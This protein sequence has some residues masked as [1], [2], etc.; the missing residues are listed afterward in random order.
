MG[1]DGFQPTHDRGF[2]LPVL[3]LAGDVVANALEREFLE[4]DRAR[5]RTRLERAQRMQM[6]GSLASGIAHNFNNI[7][8]AIL[9]YAE[10]VEPL[11]TRGTKPA[12]H[13]EEI[14]R[15]A[16]RGRDLIDNILTFGRQRDAWVRPVQVRTL[17]EEAAALLRAS[18]PS[19]VELRIEDVPKDLVVSGEPAQLQQV[20]LNLCTNAAQAMPH[21]GSICVTAEKKDVAT[22]HL[23]THGE[24][25]SGRYVCLAVIDSGFGS[26][27]G[28]RDG[29]SSPSS[30]PASR[31]MD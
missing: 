23:M 29:C 5:L 2:P 18:L 25:A 17:F 1:F 31:G 8:S 7:I 3:G 12:Q 22:H 27:K 15:A 9:G 13:V 6:I 24:V 21:G 30:P 4:R 28:W 11:V 14:R 19:G 26:T 10:M 20:I 16:E